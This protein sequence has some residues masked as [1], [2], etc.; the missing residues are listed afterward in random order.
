[1]RFSER[2]ASAGDLASVNKY[3]S[4]ITNVRLYQDR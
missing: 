4:R 3:K 1:M 2:P